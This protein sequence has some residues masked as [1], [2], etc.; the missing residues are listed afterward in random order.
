MK[1]T[2]IGDKILIRPEPLERRTKGG[3][4][5]PEIAQKGFIVR[6]EVLGRGPGPAPPGRRP[7]GRRPAL[8]GPTMSERAVAFFPAQDPL[9]GK[10][11]FQ[12]GS[13]YP[14][15]NE[16]CDACGEFRPNLSRALGAVQ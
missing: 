3:L 7:P 10:V 2:P 8:W 15:A 13:G 6:G 11:V 1:Y 16:R 9:T 4:H 14:P 12:K 5:L